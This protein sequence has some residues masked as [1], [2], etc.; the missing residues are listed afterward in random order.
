M[1]YPDWFKNEPGFKFLDEGN[2]LCIVLGP[3]QMCKYEPKG[4]IEIYNESHAIFNYSYPVSTCNIA[5]FYKSC[6][7][8]REVGEN[9]DGDWH[10]SECKPY[11]DNWNKYEGRY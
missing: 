8:I 6:W 3:G 5:Y 2:C 1:D 4:N 11:N 9:V 10:W 7:Y